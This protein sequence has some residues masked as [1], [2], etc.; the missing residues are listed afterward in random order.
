MC[1]VDV[2]SINFGKSEIFKI[3]RRSYIL[4]SFYSLTLVIYFYNLF[5]SHLSKY[6]KMR[7]LF[8]QMS[9]EHRVENENTITQSNTVAT[10]KSNQ[11]FS[12]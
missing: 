10:C 2:V 9:K 1:R 6:I 7:K 3:N 8:L 12:C 11:P 4:F 5:L